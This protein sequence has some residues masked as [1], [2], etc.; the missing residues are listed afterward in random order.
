MN[1]IPKSLGKP[2]LKDAIVE[3]R[4]TPGV[5]ANL[6]PGIFYE[7]L[8]KEGWAPPAGNIQST[9][10][11]NFG[12]RVG[13]S[14]EPIFTKDGYKLQVAENR[15]FFNITDHYP[16]WQSSYR[17]LLEKTLPELLKEDQ[18]QLTHVGLRY[19]NN[20]PTPNIF[21]ETGRFTNEPLTDFATEQKAMRW[22]MHQKRIAIV[23]NM[24]SHLDGGK[25]AVERSSVIDVTLQ[26]PVDEESADGAQSLLQ[27][28]DR[29]HVLNKQ[30]VFGHLLPEQFVAQFDPTYED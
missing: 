2:F 1:R 19:I 16:G 5:A 20:I 27:L 24:A 4:F 8:R 18:L 10:S 11:L 6:L 25:A 14:P 22:T 12:V 30:I 9:I 28:I 3:L 21:E 29:L 26:C 15:V 13:A 23:L 7:R 17:P